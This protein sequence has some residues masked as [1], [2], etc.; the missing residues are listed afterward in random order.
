MVPTA[1]PGWNGEGASAR[2]SLIRRRFV[3]RSAEQARTACP[4]LAHHPS[5][6][7]APRAA[8]C[9]DLRGVLQ[10]AEPS[11]FQPHASCQPMAP[12]GSNMVSSHRPVSAA[13]DVAGTI[14]A[15]DFEVA[16]IR[17]QPYIEH[18]GWFGRA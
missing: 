6:A 8:K 10:C 2:E 1:L 7:P 12:D 13:K 9:D 4:P 17:C 18:L 14:I 3:A 11:H 15:A 16:M 5:S